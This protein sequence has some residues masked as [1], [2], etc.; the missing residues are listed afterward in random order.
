MALDRSS[1]PAK[2][3]A[4]VRR[5]AHARSMAQRN[6]DEMSLDIV[7]A[8]I[9][10]VMVGLVLLAIMGGFGYLFGI[11]VGGTCRSG[12]FG[13]RRLRGRRDARTHGTRGGP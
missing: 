6:S 9:A 8:L 2:G 10:G 1:G 11:A 4:F 13:R 7:M 3:I 12:C 5:C